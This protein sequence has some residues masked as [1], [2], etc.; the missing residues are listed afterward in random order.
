MA[1]PELD[2]LVINSLADLDAAAKHVE[3]EL[4][5]AINVVLDQV[6]KD[7]MTKQEW[8]GVADQ[9]AKLTWLA[10]EMLVPFNRH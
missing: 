6:L 1:Q 4:Q 8:A 5:P 9:F 10:P 2:R 3:N 7:F